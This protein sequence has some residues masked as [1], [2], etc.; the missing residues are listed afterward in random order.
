MILS[1][2]VVEVVKWDNLLKGFKTV[3]DMRCYFSPLFCKCS[4]PWTVSSCFFC[5]AFSEDPSGYLFLWETSTA[6]GWPLCP[7]WTLCSDLSQHGWS[8]WEWLSQEGSSLKA[9]ARSE[10]PTGVPLSDSQQCFWN[11]CKG[12]RREERSITQ[13]LHITGWSSLGPQGPGS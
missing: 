5:L 12:R 2:R 10:S 6:P 13:S 11:E 1:H 7:L 3:H 4:H 9:G 8:V